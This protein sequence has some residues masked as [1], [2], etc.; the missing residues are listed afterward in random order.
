VVF[1]GPGVGEVDGCLR[2]VTAKGSSTTRQRRT[3]DEGVWWSN[4]RRTFHSEEILTSFT[5][6]DSTVSSAQPP[7]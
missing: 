1:L 4:R 7:R 2:V 5:R 6:H 3:W